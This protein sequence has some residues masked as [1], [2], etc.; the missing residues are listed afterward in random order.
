MFEGHKKP[1]P[2]EDEKQLKKKTEELAR[3][4]E[5]LNRPDLTPG[6]ARELRRHEVDLEQE[7][8]ELEAV[9]VRHK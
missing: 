6:M 9:P 4:R 1:E 2:S 8:T 3:V 5:S 7:I